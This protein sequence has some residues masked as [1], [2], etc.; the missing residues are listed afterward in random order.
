MAKNNSSPAS[1]CSRRL[2]TP[3]TAIIFLAP[4]SAF[5]QVG[6]VNPDCPWLVLIITYVMFTVS[7]GR[8]AH[9]QDRRLAAALY[10][11]MLKQAL[12]KISPCSIAQQGQPLHSP[13]MHAWL[14]SYCC[15]ICRPI[16]WKI[17]SKPGSK[18]G[19][20]AC[21]SCLVLD[22][23]DS[24]F[25]LVQYNE[26]W[27]PAKQIRRRSAHFLFILARTHS[28]FSFLT[29]SQNTFEG[30]S[31]KHTG[32]RMSGPDIFMW[33]GFFV[34]QL[35]SPADYI[36]VYSISVPCWSVQLSFFSSRHRFHYLAPAI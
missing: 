12:A 7:R 16:S 6:A 30:I 31:Y 34:T 17:S 27:K 11:Y 10:S 8:S 2:L 18:S 4:I 1:L 13:S 22:A 25:D 28:F 14:G 21:A 32:R 19:S 3:A 36:A 9:Q 15:P 33:Y 20:S 5:D 23:I 24:F 26:L 29:Q 35:Y